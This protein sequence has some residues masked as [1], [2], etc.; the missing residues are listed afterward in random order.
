MPFMYS[1][2]IIRLLPLFLISLL[3]PCLTFG[4]GCETADLEV[5]TFQINPEIEAG[6][7]ISEGLAKS[8]RLQAIL[9]SAA[10]N[11]GTDFV[12]P[13]E[14]RAEA[15]I[16]V[17]A[18]LSHSRGVVDG[19]SRSFVGG[20]RYALLKRLFQSVR[21]SVIKFQVTQNYKDYLEV[22]DR[23]LSFLVTQENVEDLRGK[24]RRE[25]L[26][27]V[28]KERSLVWVTLEKQS[29]QSL[30]ES[31]ASGITTIEFSP[32]QK[33]PGNFLDHDLLVHARSLELEAQYKLISAWLRE[34]LVNVENIRDP[35]LRRWILVLLFDSHEAPTSF[36]E[37]FTTKPDYRGVIFYNFSPVA[38][39]L[40]SAKAQYLPLANAWV[41]NYLQSHPIPR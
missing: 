23:V 39:T 4:H 26:S 17:Q 20:I 3:S 22:L 13:L 29:M 27:Q 15:E 40:E 5:S 33:E 18:M 19:L 32:K 12:L 10:G 16:T 35:E 36:V 28:G 30:L 14:L 11:R 21:E 7:S 2:S 1:H 24:R 31:I 34:T 41:D 9:S 37:D 25:M 6:H 38:T 8:A